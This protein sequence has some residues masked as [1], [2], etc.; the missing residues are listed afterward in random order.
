MQIIPSTSILQFTGSLS[1]CIW[2]RCHVL[3]QTERKRLIQTWYWRPPIV[4][5]KTG[6]K[7]QTGFTGVKAGRGQKVVSNRERAHESQPKKMSKAE[8]KG[9]KEHVDKSV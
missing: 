3:Y 9:S 6:E 2:A 7:N 5:Q 1:Y 8:F 4:Q